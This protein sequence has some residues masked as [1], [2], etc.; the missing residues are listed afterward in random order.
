MKHLILV[1]IASA[2]LIACGKKEESTGRHHG[3]DRAGGG[4][5]QFCI[6]G[7]EYIRFVGS[8]TVVAYAADG[9]I[10]TC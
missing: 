6:D 7:V 2:A 8:I 5:V 10:K 3:D 9:K 1:L 4:Y